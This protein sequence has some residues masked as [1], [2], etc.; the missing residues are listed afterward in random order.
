MMYL[1]GYITGAEAKQGP[2][3][4]SSKETEMRAVLFALSKYKD[5]GLS[6]VVIL[7]DT[8]E[9]MLALNGS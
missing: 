2:K 9:V 3:I 4:L 8:R 5:I 6:K 7:M 1:S